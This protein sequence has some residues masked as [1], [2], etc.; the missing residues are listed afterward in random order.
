MSIDLQSASNMMQEDVESVTKWCEEL[1]KKN[2][3]VYFNRQRELYKRLQS[4]TRPITDDEL[5]DI[6]TSIP[7]DL[8]TVSEKLTSLK[9]SHEVIKLRNKQK[10]SDLKK[11]STATT[12][13]ERTEDAEIQMIEEK[14]LDTA[15]Q[16][17]ISRIDNEISFS[18]ELIMGAKKVWDR[19]RQTENANPIGT[20]VPQSAPSIN[21]QG[22]TYYEQLQSAKNNQQPVFGGI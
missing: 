11:K 8:F 20:T 3:A 6:L 19:R 1:Y 17:V 9:T 2:F 5:E 13:T 4:K 15:Y 16:S 10:M 14:L 22:S 7:L 12:M 18:R 21:P